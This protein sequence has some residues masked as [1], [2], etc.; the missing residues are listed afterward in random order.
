M[1]FENIVEKQDA[2]DDVVQ[3]FAQG[4]RPVMTQFRRHINTLRPHNIDLRNFPCE[5][6]SGR[7]GVLAGTVAADSEGRP[8]LRT[9]P[10]CC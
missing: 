5:S 4:G 6:S 8:L 7:L 2:L 1:D 9:G 3:V 10:R